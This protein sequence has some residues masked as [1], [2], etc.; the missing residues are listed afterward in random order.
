M[1]RQTIENLLMPATYGR[2]LTRVFAPEAL[3]AGTGLKPQDLNDPE[4]RITVRQ[5][6]QYIDNTL[7]I[8]PQPDWYLAWAGTLSDHFHGPISVALMSA[9]TL[10]HGVETFIDFF[11]ARVPYLHLQA[12]REGDG[13]YAEIWPLI[14]LGD[15][16]P[17]LIETPLMILQQYMQTVY[18]VDFSAAR[19]DLDYPPTPHADCYARYFPCP[20]RF[21]AARSAL[22]FPAQW[23]ALRN[24]DYH[25]STWAHALGQCQAL[26]SSR[27]RS[28]LGEVQRLLG[29][30]FEDASRPRALPTLEDVAAQLHLAP[31]TLI[32]RLRALGTSYQAITDD[33][34]RQRAAELL[35]NDE[36]KIKAVAAALGFQNP[37]NFGKAFK[38]WFGVSPG[39]FRRGQGR[40][41]ADAP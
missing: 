2:H 17:L 24:L 1:D 23:C 38:R 7:H 5:A 31:R 4:R 29:R 20:V 41:E 27:E 40:V 14:A 26:A 36:V 30:A 13:F 19:L 32:R 35:R 6:L 10:G 8:A 9:P 33:F 34:L 11:P 12:R 3:L 25:E 39:S 15:A 21:N 28:T 22:V 16:T 37:A 18:G